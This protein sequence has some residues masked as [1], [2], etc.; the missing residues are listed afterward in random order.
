MLQPR[1]LM[2]TDKKRTAEK[3]QQQQQQHQQLLLLLQERVVDV[4]IVTSFRHANLS[5]AR[6]FDIASLRFIGRR[7]ASTVL[8]RDCLGQPI[9]RLQSSGG[10]KMQACRA[11]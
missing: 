3:S 1:K 10:P 4:A 2:T 7:S 11:R 8:S 6:R 5:W 9:L